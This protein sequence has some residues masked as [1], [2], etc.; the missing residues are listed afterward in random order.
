MDILTVILV[1]VLAVTLESL[2]ESAA[3]SYWE[4]QEVLS[5]IA[6]NDLDDDFYQKEGV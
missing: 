6:W 5:H 1:A 4:V 3:R 2:L